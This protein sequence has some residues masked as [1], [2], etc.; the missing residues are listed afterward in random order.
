M[1][2]GKVVNYHPDKGF[3]FIKPDDGTVD[4][5]VHARQLIGT[6]DLEVGQRVS[7]ET[8]L[9]QGRGKYRAEQCR[10]LD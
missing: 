5:F 6:S 10:V 4:V 8:V 1:K 7:F 3:G 2:F 9:D